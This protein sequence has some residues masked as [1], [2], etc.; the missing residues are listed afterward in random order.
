MQTISSSLTQAMRNTS[1][2]KTHTPKAFKSYRDSDLVYRILE[3][4]GI[5]NISATFSWINTHR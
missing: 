3:A 5:Y 1:P 2:H 4:K